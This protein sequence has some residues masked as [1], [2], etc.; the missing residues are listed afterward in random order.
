MSYIYLIENTINN[1]K[2]VGQTTQRLSDRLSQ[3][4]TL[5][6]K[7]DTRLY[8]AMRK[9][10]TDNFTISLLEEC[11]DSLLNEREKHWIKELNT[12][13]PNGYN[14]NPG[15][16]GVIHHTEET[17]RKISNTLK[18]RNLVSTE[19][20]EQAR[21]KLLGIKRSD[22]TREK[23]SKIAS[24]R[25]G[26]KNSFYGRTHTDETKQKIAEKAFGRPSTRRIA[27]TAYS[28]MVNI[29]FESMQQAYAYLVK[30]NLTSGARTSVISN[31]K[32]A[33]KINGSAYGFHWKF[34]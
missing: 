25:T 34:D 22:E 33:T 9:Y 11:V 20:R 29:P 26:S 24:T 8:R 10:G 23:L 1:K 13:V 17:K 6:Q 30:N 7:Y 5:S 21:F 19:K 15:G 28:N 27:I 12:Q 4:K 31:I 3:H 14:I 2:Y 16:S 32:R 18:G